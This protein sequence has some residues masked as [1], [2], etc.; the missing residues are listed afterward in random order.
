MQVHKTLGNGIQ[1]V[2]YQGALEIEMTFAR[3]N[4]EREK[5]WIFFIAVQQ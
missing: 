2:I 4:F 1:E 3:L 5:E